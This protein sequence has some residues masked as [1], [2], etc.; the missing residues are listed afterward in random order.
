MLKNITTKVGLGVTGAMLMAGTAFA[1]DAAQNGIDA[2]QGDLTSNTLGSQVASVTNLLIYIIGI[3]SVIMLIIGGFRYVLSGGNEKGTQAA[4][5]TILYAI[6]GVV[7]ALLAY[8]I[9][10]FVI[11]KF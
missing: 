1:N 5:D 10:N 8:S 4:K 11:S 6:I 3:V 7:V 9:M 2:A